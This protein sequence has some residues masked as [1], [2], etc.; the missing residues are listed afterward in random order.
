MKTIYVATTNQGK[1]RELREIF[2]KI[3]MDVV[4]VFDKFDD[5]EDVEETG[6]TFEENA[7][8]KA[9]TIAEI[10]KIPVLADDS[11][12][13]VHALGG[14]PGV[15]SA[16]YAGEEKNDQENLNKVLEKLEGKE[17]RGASFKCVMAF[18]RPSMETVISDGTCDGHISEKPQGEG[19]FGYDPIFVPA[20]YNETM[21][22]IGP[23]E[24]NKISHR[25]RA[26]DS[27]IDQIKPLL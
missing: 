23:D 8:L 7:R 27:M 22:Q 17:D 3:K 14:E 13:E 24:K 4:S 18:A 21:A 12:L 20:G 11:G 1:L 26:I 2:S 10:Y 9:E 19:G 16:R 25:K 6:V 5:V 15:Y